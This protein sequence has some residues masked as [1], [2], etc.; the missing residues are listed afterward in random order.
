MPRRL[1]NAKPLIYVFCEGESEQVYTD[2]LKKRFQDVA[3]IK[4]P[5]ATG[6]FDEADDL[7][8]KNVKYK[9]SADVTDEIWFFF[10]VET[11][12]IGKWNARLAVMK[13]LRKLRK[14][15]DIRV[16]LLMTTGCIEYWLMLHYKLYAPPL[17][18][19]AEKE[20]VLVELMT[21]E[22]AYSKGNRQ[23][24]FRIAEKYQA[25]VINSEKTVKN[26]VQDGLPGFEDT[27]IRNEWLYKNCKTFSNVYEAIKYLEV[28]KN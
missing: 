19:V 5:S 12:D 28:L 18:T 8:R 13:R 24:T 10:D 1:K 14:N 7:F 21:K 11:K 15:P 27:D 26:L 25:A 4:R 2:F 9:N 16:R 3:V 22:P 17:Q 23:V 20:R 6:L